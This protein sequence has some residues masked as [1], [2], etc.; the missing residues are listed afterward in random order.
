[1]LEFLSAI[2]NS[3]KRSCNILFVAAALSYIIQMMIIPKAVT[4]PIVIGLGAYIVFYTLHKGLRNVKIPLYSKLCIPFVAWVTLSIFWT[5][6]PDYSFVLIRVFLCFEFATLTGLFVKDESSFENVLRGMVF[7]GFISSIVVLSMQY[8]Y[9]GMIRLGRDI[10]GSAMEFSGGLMVSCYCCV[11]L[12]KMKR[13][14]IYIVLFTM[15]LILGALSG[16]R[17]AVLYPVLFLCM[18]LFFYHQRF[19]G[20]LKVLVISVVLG[21]SIL[22]SCMTIPA[23]YNVV[24]RR[25]ETLIEDRTD[26]Q[27]YMERSEMKSYAIHLWKERPLFGWGCHGFAAKHRSVGKYAYSHC[28]Y[29]EVLS[30]FGLVGF[31]LWYGPYIH[32]FKRRHLLR[33]AKGNWFQTFFISL[34]ALLAVNISGSIIFVNV[35]TMMLLALIFEFLNRRLPND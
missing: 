24:G 10:Y 16:S 11:A 13:K 31:V 9:I 26:D 33:N 20:L 1:M 30:C 25:M 28:D 18:F 3:A 23:L 2:L 7:G 6:N 12:W 22:Y 17:T 19:I 8:Q 29:T 35:K 21:F 4:M 5:V 14:K 27:S 34:L 32:I 15:F